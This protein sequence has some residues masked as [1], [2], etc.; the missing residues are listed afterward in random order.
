MNTYIV[1]VKLFYSMHIPFSLLLVESFDVTLI[2]LFKNEEN[3]L[4]KKSEEKL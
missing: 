4:K 2:V 3:F 1:G